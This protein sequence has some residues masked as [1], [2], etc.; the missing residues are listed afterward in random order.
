[1]KN[2]ATDAAKGF[3][4][5]LTDVTKRILL[6]NRNKDVNKA[7]TALIDVNRA[8]IK[9]TCVSTSCTY[10]VYAIQL[11]Y[12]EILRFIECNIEAKIAW[13]KDYGTR[14]Y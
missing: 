4:I 7:L 3:A 8:Y 14:Y 6:S 11:D 1:M 5:M 9:I 13:I 2:I 12:Q 10:V